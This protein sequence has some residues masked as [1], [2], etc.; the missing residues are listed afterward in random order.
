MTLKK[1][2]QAFEDTISI[3]AKLFSNIY[4]ISKKLFFEAEAFRQR[5][6]LAVVASSLENKKPMYECCPAC[7]KAHLLKKAEGLNLGRAVREVIKNMANCETG[8]YGY[9]LDDGKLVKI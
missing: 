3:E 6:G 1:F 9:Y 4:L 8:H 2:S 7:L 5:N